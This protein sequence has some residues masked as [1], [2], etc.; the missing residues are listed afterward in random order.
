MSDSATAINI[1]GVIAGVFGTVA[2][3][4]MLL[5]WFT[6]RLPSAKLPALVALMESTQEL[7]LQVI[8]DGS[9]TDE[10]EIY[11][12]YLNLFSYVFPS[13]Y[14]MARSHARPSNSIKIRIGDMGADNDDATLWQ[15]DVRNW[16]KGLSGKIRDLSSTLR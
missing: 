2:L 16:C 8:R 1:W 3:V 13:L 9:L 12:C 14:V 10:N 7:F 5:N 11:Q 6:N 4:P 15:Q